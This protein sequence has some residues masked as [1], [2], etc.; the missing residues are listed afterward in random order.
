[1][2][3]ELCVRKENRNGVAGLLTRRCFRSEISYLS[4]LNC[5]MLI[6]VYSYFISVPKCFMCFSL[7][8]FTYMFHM[9]CLYRPLSSSWDLDRLNSPLLKDPYHK[10]F[11]LYYEK[12]LENVPKNVLT[13]FNSTCDIRFVYS[14]MHG[15]GFPY[16]EKAFEIARLKPL[17]PVTEQQF[18]DPEFP[19]VKFP[20][21]EEG[22]TSLLLS[23]KL[24]EKTK[25]SV[26]LANDPDADR[27]ACAEFI[28][29]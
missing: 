7:F 2:T 16:V 19:T 24:A 23:F 5:E 26:I 29:A 27:L 11:D 4:Y 3:N 6:L 20:N 12:L 9:M 17:I 18:A 15:V 10:M 28:E 25:S 13:E 21:P 22:K 8:F 1:M 14:A